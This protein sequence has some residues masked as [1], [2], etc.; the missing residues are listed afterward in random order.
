[1]LFLPFVPNDWHLSPTRGPTPHREKQRKWVL[2]QLH[3]LVLAWAD[4]ITLHKP[5]SVQ[6]VSAAVKD[7]IVAAYWPTMDALLQWPLHRERGK[8]LQVW[9]E[10]KQFPGHSAR[11]LWSLDLDLWKGCTNLPVFL[12]GK[13][14]VWVCQR[15][16][17][18]AGQWGQPQPLPLKRRDEPLPP[19]AWELDVCNKNITEMNVYTVSCHF[20][21]SKQVSD[22]R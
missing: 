2:Q 4:N 6:R 15:V 21:S 7:Q 5:R 17:R 16:R 9:P 22:V 10:G 13:T 11:F 8:W 1:M 19:A 14:W 3:E 18:E 12:G 20:S